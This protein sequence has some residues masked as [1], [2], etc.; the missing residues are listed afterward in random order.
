[1][2]ILKDAAERTSAWVT[3][4]VVDE[5]ELD[6]RVRSVLR[7]R[8]PSAVSVLSLPAETLRD[9]VPAELPDHVSGWIGAGWVHEQLLQLAPEPDY[10]FCLDPWAAM[11]IGRHRAL[12]PKAKW[13]YVKDVPARENEREYWEETGAWLE[14]LGFDHVLPVEALVPSSSGPIQKR[15]GSWEFRPIATGQRI[16]VRYSSVLRLRVF[17]ESLLRQAEKPGVLTVVAPEPS[18]ELGRF[19]ACLRLANPELRVEIAAAASLNAIVL[20]DG[21]I[22]PPDFLSR[23]SAAVRRVALDAKVAA[24]ILVGNL[25]PHPVYADLRA[26]HRG[27][28]EDLLAL[29]EL[30]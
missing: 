6:R 3:T 1:M 24:Q 25:D 7:P 5:A 29:P 27:A 10:V 23:S 28:P 17:V 22:L 13:V 19:A 9:V 4:Q 8:D 16:A 12:L 11:A 18:V 15:P 14:A 30:A 20:D 2:T 21:L 26:A